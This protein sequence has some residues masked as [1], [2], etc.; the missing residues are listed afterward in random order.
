M[1]KLIPIILMLV[2]LLLGCSGQG[3]AETTAP[4]EPTTAATEPPGLYV[5][6]S[7]VEQYTKGTVKLFDLSY[8]AY[9]QIYKMGNRLLLGGYYADMCVLEGERCAVVAELE[10]KSPSV[11]VT[12]NGV[13][14]YD[15]DKNEAV[16]LDASLQE[17]RRVSLPEGVGK[18]GQGAP[19]FS[20]DGVEVYY[21][22]GQEVRAFNTD[23]GITRMIKSLSCTSLVSN[24]CFFDGKLIFLRVDNEAGE[25]NYVFVS[26]ENGKTVGT[27]NNLQQLFT[28]GDSY[29]LER[30]D[31]GVT[32]Y[33]FGVLGEERGQ[34]LNILNGKAVS[35]LEVGGLV[36][37]TQIEN[38]EW[39]FDFYEQSTGKR[40]SSVNIP[41]IGKPEAFLGDPQEHAVWIL[42][43]GDSGTQ[44]LLR[45][46]IGET[47]VEDEQIYTSPA[48]S[49]AT[50]DEDGLSLCRKQAKEMSDKHGVDIRI[51]EEAVKYTG[52]YTAE[53]EYQTAAINQCL[54]QLESVLS[55]FPQDFL[56][57][58]VLSRI[59]ICI[60]RSISGSDGAVQY[61]YDGDAFILLP[62]TADVRNT[63]MMALSGVVDSHVLGNSPNYDYW[64]D[65]NP[66]G[67][68]YG[69]E[70]TYSDTYLSGETMAFF[71]EISM[72]SVTEDRCRIFFEAMKP[73]NADAFKSEIMQQKL[74]MLCKAIRDAWR[75][76]RKSDIYPW[77]QYLTESIAYTR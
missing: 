54:D 63:F 75:W 13:V 53:G 34:Q 66:E 36:S 50:P 18:D 29:F 67:F 69:D 42:I 60:V 68:V 77:E 22:Q 74:L 55:E 37:Y 71:D 70:T 51:W 33:L 6:N 11:L 65:L 16:Y 61:W 23:Q 73:D 38:G 58:S 20:K 5:E 31:G 1:K 28:C 41:D 24:D 57:K 56:Y 10:E 8:N 30:T 21:C 62:A 25:M 44:K 46:D 52:G 43:N 64:N 7:E 2:V 76:E 26:S 27:D 4:T 3:G 15:G 72:G 39:Q 14:Y 32:Q 47:P 9:Q 49:A 12:E 59:R 45:W 48:Y 19:S 40:T 35:V 17:L